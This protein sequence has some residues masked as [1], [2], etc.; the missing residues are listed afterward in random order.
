MGRTTLTRA[1][2]IGVSFN[3]RKYCGR[4]FLKH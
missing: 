1:N 3:D 2:F 4:N